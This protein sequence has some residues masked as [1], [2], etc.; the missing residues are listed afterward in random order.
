ML[1]FFRRNLFINYIWLLLFIA[2]CLVYYVLSPDKIQIFPFELPFYN[3][4]KLQIPF[5]EKPLFQ[6]LYGFTLIAIQ[7]VMVAHLVIKNRMSRQL[8]LIPGAV[9]ALFCVWVLNHGVT[10]SILLA[11][12]FFILS[13]QSLFKIY[14]KYKPIS[15]LF[16][17]GFFLGIAALI[18]F[19][20][21]IYFF[22]GIIGLMSLR[23]I[24]LQEFLQYSTGLLTPIFL[25]GVALIYYGKLDMIYNYLDFGIYM[26]NLDLSNIFDTIKLA[27]V[28]MICFLLFLLQTSLLKKKKFDVIKKIEMCYWFLLMGF[29][30]LF[31]SSQQDAFHM[32]IISTPV[33]LLLGLN[34]EERQNTIIK[35]FGFILILIFYIYLMIGMV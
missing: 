11:N 21:Y 30:S 31:I 28:L 15:I 25:S 18:Y 4:H 29:F 8:S 6:L 20:Y 9:M 17:S 1:T 12:L 26:P 23:G 33:S 10:H 13:I 34:L 7:S 2:G 27:V 14:K 22:V 35:E 5:A 3:I 24:K 19:P 16:N 32:I